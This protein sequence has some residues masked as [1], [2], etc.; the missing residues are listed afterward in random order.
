MSNSNGELITPL[1]PIGI[2]MNVDMA[3][4]ICQNEYH[5]SLVPS[6]QKVQ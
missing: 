6:K 5:C 3:L 1:L 4:I 2:F